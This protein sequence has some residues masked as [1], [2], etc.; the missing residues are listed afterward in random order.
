MVTVGEIARFI[1][2]LAPLP[3]AEPWDKVGLQVGRATAGVGA[4]IVC[5][6]VTDA[7]LDEALAWGCQL[8]VSHHPLIFSDFTGLTDMSATGRL[9]LKAAE[10][11]LAV[12][13]VHTNLDKASGG[14][15][16]AM[17]ARLGL[18]D[19]E[20]LEA[21]EAL[22]KLVVFVPKAAVAAVKAAIG[23]A[24]G[25]RIGLYSHC[26]FSS[27]GIGSFRPLPGAD[28]SQGE[29][30]RDN[31]VEEYR[32]EVEVGQA[33]IDAVVEAMR[34]AHP[35][36]EVAYD[37]YEQRKRDQRHGLGRVGNVKPGVA[38]DDFIALCV[39][40]FGDHVRYAG[41]PGDR[42]DKNTAEAPVSRV[43]V[44]GG[45]GGRLFAAAKRAGADLLVTGDIK[46]HDALN[47]VDMGLA[48]VDAGHDGTEVIGMEDLGKR[49]EREFDIKF[50]GLET[51]SSIWQGVR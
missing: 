13:V 18:I 23:D 36:E 17:A 9:A 19:V 26:A 2:K 39:K 14:I 7:I 35:Y 3:L 51:K 27:A 32:L 16:D 49:L 37:L 11:G 46:Y 31:Q 12:Y 30:G 48:V 5:L 47:A 45:S 42:A 8:V 15:S 44:C 25:G 43:A 33:E 20:V 21:A 41:R 22:L 28:P 50:H 1:E 10:K 6:D 38:F 24:G 29:V 4:A 34:R 40:I